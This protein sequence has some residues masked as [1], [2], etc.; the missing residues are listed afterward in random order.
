MASGSGFLD[1]TTFHWDPELLQKLHVPASRLSDLCDFN[2]PAQGFRAPF[3][4]RWPSLRDVPWSPALG[5]G[6]CSNVGCGC[7]LPASDAKGRPGAGSA[8]RSAGRTVVM[9]G[10]TGALRV[11]R[12]R[13]DKGL[14][15]PV[16]RGLWGYLM[17]RSRMLLG[18]VLGDGGNLGE[19]MSETLAL[20]M[21]REEADAALLA[22]EPAGHGLT[23]LGADVGVVE[24]GYDGRQARD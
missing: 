10:T 3:A 14:S 11:V 6:A 22:A 24:G 5:D 16:P 12:R 7:G 9:I 1:G 21:S 13:P 8:V 23:V 4:E 19:W 17:D 20:G 2:E 18:G 15:V